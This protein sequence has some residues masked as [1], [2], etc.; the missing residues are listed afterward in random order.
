MTAPAATWE[1]AGLARLEAELAQAREAKNRATTRKLSAQTLYERGP[2][3][4]KCLQQLNE[5][6]PAVLVTPERLAPN[7]GG[8]RCTLSVPHHPQFANQFVSLTR[9]RGAVPH[10]AVRRAREKAV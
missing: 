1:R 6:T 7:V 3:M 9:A 8:V 4:V 2:D 5:M 10:R